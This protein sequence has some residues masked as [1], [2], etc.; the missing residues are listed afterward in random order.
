MPNTKNHPVG[1]TP[2]E[3]QRI[4]EQALRAKETPSKR[5][6]NPRQA[7][8]QSLL[9]TAWCEYQKLDLAQTLEDAIKHVTLLPKQPLSGNS[10]RV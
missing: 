4:W 1:M 2:L 7:I 10:S 5:M 6:K 3:Y 9:P 8:Y